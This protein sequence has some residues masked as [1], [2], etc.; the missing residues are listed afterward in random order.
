MAMLASAATAHELTVGCGVESLL[1]DGHDG[2]ARLRA[3]TTGLRVV[4]AVQAAPWVS[5]EELNDDRT[6]YVLSGPQLG[7]PLG[8]GVLRCRRACIWRRGSVDAGIHQR[9]V[10]ARDRPRGRVR[11][12]RGGARR[13]SRDHV[14][15]RSS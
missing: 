7:A 11:R 13:G 12:A 9:A 14:S 4:D 1:R 3:A 2:L 6:F 8:I 10:A 15:K 5:L